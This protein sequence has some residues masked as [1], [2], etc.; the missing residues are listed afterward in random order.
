MSSYPA[1]MDE[2]N[3]Y[4]GQTVDVTFTFTESDGTTLVDLSN[5]D[6]IVMEIRGDPTA[7]SSII[8]L[9]TT[10]NSN[11]SRLFNGGALGTV[12]VLINKDDTKVFPRVKATTDIFLLYSDGTSDPLLFCNNV[13]IAMRTTKRLA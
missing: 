3:I 9:N 4:Q 10:P 8:A 6:E 13:N 12:R 11:G 7:G 1:E 5:V 2:W